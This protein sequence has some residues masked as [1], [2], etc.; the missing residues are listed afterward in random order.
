MKKEVKI[1]T[2]EEMN[3]MSPEQL[4][5]QIKELQTEILVLRE[6]KKGIISEEDKKRFLKEKK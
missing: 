3:N 5:K 4:K 2:E 6:L 1:L